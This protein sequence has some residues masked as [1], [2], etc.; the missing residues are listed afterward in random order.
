MARVACLFSRQSPWAPLVQ[1][2]LWAEWRER[3]SRFPVAGL[4][5]PSRT[6]SFP[7][8]PHA[9]AVELSA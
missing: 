1:G 3:L 6:V 8:I 7:W 2:L 5:C 9:V 4:R